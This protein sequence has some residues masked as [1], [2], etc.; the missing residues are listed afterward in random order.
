MGNSASPFQTTYTLQVH[1]LFWPFLLYLP[2]PLPC[3]YFYL[4][5][6]SSLSFGSLLSPCL[7]KQN[8]SFLP[9]LPL[10]IIMLSVLTLKPR[11]RRP[12]P[13]ALP[14]GGQRAGGGTPGKGPG[15]SSWVCGSAP[16]STGTS[17]NPVS[18]PNPSPHL[19]PHIDSSSQASL[20][21]FPLLNK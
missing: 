20:P 21:Q 17:S 13:Q 1:F 5:P 16:G 14:G 9:S 8:P 4:P 7:T 19:Q 15:V 11:D 18:F 3:T 12:G 2:N 10:Q 6:P